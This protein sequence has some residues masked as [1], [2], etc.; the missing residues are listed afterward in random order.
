[1]AAETARVE[2]GFLGGGATSAQLD[3]AGVKALRKA[4]DKGE[5]GLVELASD[6]GTL[7][8]RADQISFLRIAQ[9]ESRVGF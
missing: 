4:V 9:R 5:A 3:D 2:I 8:V 1:M 7:L 6:G